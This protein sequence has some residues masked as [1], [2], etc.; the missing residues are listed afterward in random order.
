MSATPVGDEI[1]LALRVQEIDREQRILTLSAL[2][3]SSAG[4]DAAKGTSRVKLPKVTAN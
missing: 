2:A 4:T 3:K 1:T